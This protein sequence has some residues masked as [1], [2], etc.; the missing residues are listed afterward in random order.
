ML[1]LNKNVYFDNKKQK[2]ILREILKKHIPGKI[3]KRKKQGFTGP[4][5]Y[6]M[7]FEWYERNLKNS[8]LVEAGIINISA[9]NN[10]LQN[11]DHWRLWKISV[12]E[13]WFIK[14]MC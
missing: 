13:K 6:Y 7:N 2:I 1:S 4:D 9:I 14:W 5:K 8:K 3:L 10:Y 11:K 12:L